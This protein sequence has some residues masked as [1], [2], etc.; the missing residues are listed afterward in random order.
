M[1]KF[2]ISWLI[3]LLVAGSS[4]IVVSS[5]MSGPAST[6]ALELLTCLRM[7]TSLWYPISHPGALSHLS[8]MGREMSTG[9]NV[10]ML[11]GQRAKAGMAGLIP[12]VDKRLG[13]R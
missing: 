7:V 12:Y 8:Y 6:G 5:S 4:R 1:Y 2:V 10:V 13:G 3:Y 11:C 9:Q